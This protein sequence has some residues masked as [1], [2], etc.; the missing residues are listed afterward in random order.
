MW[1]AQA[2]LGRKGRTSL[3]VLHWT[4]AVPLHPMDFELSKDMPG[5][6][7]MTAMLGG[8]LLTPDIG[9]RR[10]HEGGTDLFRV[11]LGSAEPISFPNQP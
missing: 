11:H 9:M 2:I 10:V 3:L 1:Q 8:T 6:I 7:H 4:G 5:T